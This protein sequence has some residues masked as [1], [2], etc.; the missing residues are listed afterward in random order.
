M[1]NKIVN[2]ELDFVL[3]FNAML[4]KSDDFQP[5]GS[6]CIEVAR[7]AWR[8]L[9]SSWNIKRVPFQSPKLITKPLGNSNGKGE[10]LRSGFF[11]KEVGKYKTT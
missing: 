9:G 6:S 7:I 2:L 10:N 4:H 11:F 8:R 1:L 5:I 3:K